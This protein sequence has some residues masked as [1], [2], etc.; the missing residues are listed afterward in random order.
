MAQ[1]TYIT[2]AQ[3]NWSNN[4]PPTSNEPLDTGFFTLDCSWWDTSTTPYTRWLCTDPTVGALAWLSLAAPVPV[5]SSPTFSGIT[6]A[7][8]LSTTRDANV[9]YCIPASITSIIGTET[10]TATLKYADNI[11]MSTNVIT[12]CVDQLS[13]GGIVNFTVAN[14]LQ[15]TGDIPRGKFRQVT[16]TVAGGAT[17]PTTISSTSEKLI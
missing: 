11:G 9:V 17:A 13:T 4:R 6:T 14:M 8:Q 16:F 5:Y 12:R 1:P 15:L 2:G 3:D 10:I 7:T